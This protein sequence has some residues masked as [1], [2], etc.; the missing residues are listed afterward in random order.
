MEH[1]LLCEAPVC[2]GD[3]NDNFKNEVVWYAGEPVCIKTPYQKFQKRQVDI[4]KWV[5][6]GRFKNM[7]LAYNA[8]ELETRAI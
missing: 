3:P 1:Y 5:A 6:K 4:N 7:D 2:A 8:T